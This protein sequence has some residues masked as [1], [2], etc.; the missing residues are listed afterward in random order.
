MSDTDPRP[1][2]AVAPAPPAARIQAIDA[3]RGW[4][5]LGI[6]FMNMPAFALPHKALDNPAVAGGIEGADWW[7]W[8]ACT[9][10]ADG[11]MR[12][13]F[14][15]LFGAGAVLL[16]RRAESSGDA[17]AAR[18][19]D[20]YTRRMLWLMAL[21]IFDAFVLGWMGDVLY[22]YG[23]VGLVLYPL[24]R[25]R[26][27]RLI[28]AACL[29]LA[30][31][32]AM[33]VVRHERRDA[34]RAE[35]AALKEAAAAGKEL[36][37]EQEK[38]IERWQER[39]K[40][41][42]PPP[43]AVAK[44]VK[45]RSEGYISAIV[46]VAPVIMEWNGFPI[47]L[48]SDIL[49]FMILGMGLAGLGVLTGERTTRF[50][51]AG[52]VLTLPLGWLCASLGHLEWSR[53]GFDPEFFRTYAQGAAWGYVVQRLLLSFGYVCV[54]M[55]LARLPAL[56]LLTGWMAAAGRMPLTNYLAQSLICLFIFTGAGA[57]LFGSISRIHLVWMTVAIFV[58]QVVFSV[59]WLK[60]FHFGPC[61]WFWRWM[62]YGTR[63]PCVIA[64]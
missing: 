4:V 26:P 30:I 62:A 39:A 10:L 57:G 20:V 7:A 56:A 42:S 8:F 25:V 46:A 19:G 32:V 28:A 61:E 33:N 50:Y 36:T 11:K 48:D 23:L 49:P 38:K 16:T 60:R 35:V 9:V 1:A 52:A 34:R 18:S 58:P 17:G 51:L 47:Y 45:A 3:L 13:I 59:W 37:K 14:S 6:L 22:W 63:P 24:R 43:E 15:M 53:S 12:A 40:E 27:S 2:P 41:I 64:R 44:E 55:L 29:L 31:G 54:A 21:G 5:L